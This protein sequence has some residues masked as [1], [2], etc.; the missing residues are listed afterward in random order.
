MVYDVHAFLIIIMY[1]Y[2]SRWA[3][4]PSYPLCVPTPPIGFGRWF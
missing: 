3:L 2:S 1:G 4:R